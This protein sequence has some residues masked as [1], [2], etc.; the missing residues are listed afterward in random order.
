[1]A[2]GDEIDRICFQACVDRK[3]YPSP[4]N[5]FK[6]PKSLCVSAN[7]VIC[8]GIPYEFCLRVATGRGPVGHVH[9]LQVDVRVTRACVRACVHG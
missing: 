4:L 6:F 8:H 3:I 5:Y 2:T 9:T 1:M 7:E